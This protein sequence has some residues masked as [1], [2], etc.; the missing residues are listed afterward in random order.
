MHDRSRNAEFAPV[1][2][3]G[4]RHAVERELGRSVTDRLRR[5]TIA[6]TLPMLMMRPRF[7][8]FMIF[9][10]SRLHRNAEVRLVSMICCQSESV[11]VRGRNGLRDAGIVDQDVEAAERVHRRLEQV[12][13]VGFLAHVGR[14]HQRGAVCLA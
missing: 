10:A 9:I 14:A 7:C 4:M 3:A 11:Q 2:R 12:E 5:G 13:D 1:E 8:C 6:D